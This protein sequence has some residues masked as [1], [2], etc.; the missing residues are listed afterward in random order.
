MKKG[1]SVISSFIMIILLI[2]LF[3]ALSYVFLTS[4]KV[5]KKIVFSDLDSIYVKEKQINYLYSRG[6]RI[7]SILSL[8]PGATISGNK[9]LLKEKFNDAQILYEFEL[10]DN[11]EKLL[12]EKKITEQEIE[13]L[14]RE[15]KSLKDFYYKLQGV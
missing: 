10:Q 9:V 5:D 13:N 11:F 4:V 2:A 12:L 3:S 15:G 6:E 1:V 7:E 14:K 8:Y